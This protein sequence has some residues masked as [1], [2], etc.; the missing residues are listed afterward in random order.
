M[1]ALNKYLQEAQ[2][3]NEAKVIA[4]QIKGDLEKVTFDKPMDADD[5][6]HDI[7]GLDLE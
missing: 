1:E 6:I 7:L 5:F 2:V 4:E 3:M